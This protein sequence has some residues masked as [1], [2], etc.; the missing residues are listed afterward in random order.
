M[1][2]DRDFSRQEQEAFVAFERPKTMLEASLET[3]ILRANLCR[4]VARWN[5]EDRV[6]LDHFGL[7]PVSKYRAGFYQTI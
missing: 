4:Y 7:C 6:I 3:E 2:K 1:N 5:K